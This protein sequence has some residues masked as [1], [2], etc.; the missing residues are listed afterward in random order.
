M[1][2]LNNVVSGY[3]KVVVCRNI[4]INVG[5]GEFVSIVG[6]N[7]AGKTTLLKT[8]SGLLPV[9]EG[10]ILFNGEDISNM[11]SHKI[12]KRRLVLGAGMESLFAPMTVFDNLMVNLYTFR[13]LMSKQE[14]AEQ[15]EYVFTVFPKLKERKDQKAGTLSGGERQMLSLA[16]ALICKPKMLMLDEPSLGLAPIVI[17]TLFDTIK[18]VVKEQKLSVLMVEQNVDRSL[19]ISDRGYVLDVGQ[20]VLEGSAKSLLHDK[21][22]K[23]VY[24]GIV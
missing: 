14:I 15:F 4:S 6:A 2:D 10:T 23:D 20:I 11:E 7:G 1:L 22:V 3:E 13:H 9:S 21:R 5:E 24:L 18:R 19:E 16:K 12:S 17:D 8:I